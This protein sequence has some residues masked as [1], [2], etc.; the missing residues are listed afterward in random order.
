M[1]GK[2][3]VLTPLIQRAVSSALAGE[4][5]AHW[6]DAV[7]NR[8]NGDNRTHVTSGAGR[9]DISTPRDRAGTCEPP[10]VQKR[11]TVLTET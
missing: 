10:R 7:S 6:G 2:E 8:R 3:G 5:D 4:M 1:T 11:Q 9:L